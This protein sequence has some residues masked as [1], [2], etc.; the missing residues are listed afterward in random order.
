MATS[1][2]PPASD[3][4]AVPLRT[5]LDHPALSLTR[6][7]GPDSGPAGD[8]P[9]SVIGA[10]ELDDPARYLLGGELVLTAGVHFPQTDRAV[11]AYVARLVAAGTAA[12]GFGVTPVYAEVPPALVEAC[13]RHGLPLLRVPPATPFV[14]VG[15]AFQRALAEARSRDLRRVSEA[16]AALAS[17]AARPDAVES[18]L[19]Q[20]AVRLGA[21]AVLFDRGP[22]HTETDTDAEAD[23]DAADTTAS[24]GQPRELFTAGPRPAASVRA[25]LRALAH[26]LPSPSGPA[27]ASAAEHHP[28]GLLVAQALP[29]GGAPVLGLAAAPGVRLTAVERSVT[30]LGVVLLSLLTG[31]RQALG[32]AGRG[33]AG[34]VRLL[35]GGPGSDPEAITALL[36][37]GSPA[38]R[39]LVVHGRRALPHRTDRQTAPE[40]TESTESTEAA[41]APIHRAA[42]ATALGTPYLDLDSGAGTLRAL[43]AAPAADHTAG[44]DGST[45]LD[46][47]A[48][49]GWTLGLSA[50]APAGRLAIADA[51]AERAL[52]HA[53]ATGEPVG[54]HRVARPGLADLVEP[55]PA[56]ALARER[57]A[58]LADAGPPGPDALLETLRTWLSLPG[59][60]DRTATALELHRNTVRQ[61]IDRIAR[62]LET[63]LSD[64]GERAE[65]WFALRWR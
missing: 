60:W 3:G 50:P 44:E 28:E 14:A 6:L 59:S 43:I 46:V 18:V 20:L 22:V 38:P 31:P 32:D 5:L 64:A 39:W 54:R 10:T 1:P 57:F 62:L 27:P 61:R 19:R 47:P 55:E 11:D 4:P 56:A 12:I 13:E 37:P 48:R 21:W 15:R 9:I 35:L 36:Q 23:T 7:A 42:L 26:R 29:G 49:L 41:S 52:R 25:R 24:G 17:A 45:G 34:L 8:P 33:G 63:D 53:L 58:P 40:R 2:A 30:G 65:L 51:E 16:Q